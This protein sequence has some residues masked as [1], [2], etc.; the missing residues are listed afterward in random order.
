MRRTYGTDAQKVSSKMDRDARATEAHSLPRQITS[1]VGR[2]Q[3]ILAI[4]QRLSEPTCQLLTLVGPGGIG[5]TRLALE[6][7]HRTSH[8]CSDGT[9]FVAL[10]PLRSAAHIPSTIAHALD[11]PVV[12]NGDLLQQIIRYLHKRRVLL[13]LDNFEHLIE[14][15][16]MVADILL[17][18]QDVQLLVTS[19]EALKLHEEWQWPVKGL[20]YPSE[21]SDADSE[22][23]SAVRLFTERARQICPESDFTDHRAAISRICQLVEGIPLAIE[24]AANW[25]KAL[26]CEAIADAI[27][28]N[29]DFL[30]SREQNIPERHRSMRAVYNHSWRLLPEEERRVFEKL[31]VFRGGFS[32]Q[33]AERVA[34]ATLAMLASLL[35]KSFLQQST[36]GRYDI[37]E[38]L[39]QYGS[40]QLNSFGSALATADE[41]A[42]FF[43]NYVAQ[44][45]M[46][47]EGNRQFVGLNNIVADFENIRAAWSH[48]VTRHAYNLIDPMVDS[49]YWFGQWHTRDAEVRVL[50]EMAAAAFK[51]GSDE[52]SHPVWGRVL[53]RALRTDLN[54]IER[55][56]ELARLYGNQSEAAFCLIERS[57]YRANRHQFPQAISDIQSALNIYRQ[58]GDRFGILVALT[59]LVY[60]LLTAGDT[61]SADQYLDEG[62]RL[63]RESGNQPLLY[64]LLFYVGWTS[65][66][67]G[68]YQIGEETF[69]EAL[70]IAEHM[71]MRVAAADTIGSLAFVAFLHGDVR[72]AKDW[73]FHDLETVT[74][75]TAVGEQGF[76]KIV[77][78]HITC[79][80]G[81]S[82]K[83]RQIAEE[84]LLLVRPHPVR[85]RFIARVMAMAECG[86]GN[87]DRAREHARKALSEEVHPGTWLW[88]L[89]VFALLMADDG[90][91]VYAAQLLGLV[92]THPASATGW[93][94]TWEPLTQLREQLASALGQ[95]GYAEAWER[96]SML[97]L[98]TVV[99]ELL[100]MC[101]SQAKQPLAEPLT[102][103]ELEVLRLIAS[104]LSNREIAET[105]TVVEGTVRT[106]VYNLCQKLAARSRTHAVARARALHLLH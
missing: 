62:V 91:P 92:F 32:R 4:I 106:H 51:P 28:N 86:L 95:T 40:E 42:A 99:D 15:S 45:E 79:L 38:L 75:I 103:R 8:H 43:A 71:G 73:I 63:A 60:C 74:R 36:N 78:A 34:G 68:S 25:T 47:L 19:R 85:E 5:K 57:L 69:R 26:T 14:G 11:L 29:L 72:Q 53:V 1:F 49:L 82:L 17:G 88:I 90:N 77:L 102:D 18:A 33:A 81:D 66:F 44:C 97:N 84:A 65:C 67:A 6:V 96:G 100:L 22:E 59:R 23:N 39:R 13:I 76:A 31:S 16:G 7:A 46:D 52:N 37:H 30:T 87:F 21:A 56:L 70:A 104:G 83:A 50:F 27:Q 24:M 105:L 101:D 94:E 89:P 3:E 58:L 41:H 98:N 9:Y 61:R 20:R 64:H 55:G 48:A 12:D 35:D 10:Q 80:E 54:A 2:E 93:L